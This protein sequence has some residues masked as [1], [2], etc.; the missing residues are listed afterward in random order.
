[1]Q[2]HPMARPMRC[3]SKILVVSRRCESTVVL[4]KSVTQGVNPRVFWVAVLTVGDGVAGGIGRVVW[5]RRTGSAN[6]AE[7]V[8]EAVH[9]I[10]PERTTIPSR[11]QTSNRVCLIE[12]FLI[13]L[14]LGIQ[15]RHYPGSWIEVLATDYDARG[16]L[17]E[18]FF[19][20]RTQTGSCV[21]VGLLWDKKTR[22]I[23]DILGGDVRNRMSA[24]R[25]GSATRYGHI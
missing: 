13:L 18:R 7:P 4:L 1:M 11:K 12:T 3:R 25:S 9:I 17:A 10:D 23:D 21:K 20:P 2:L 15:R 22:C 8:L 24:K 16:L 19:K 14:I 6:P 5:Y